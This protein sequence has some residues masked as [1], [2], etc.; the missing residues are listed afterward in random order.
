M[1]DSPDDVAALLA[2]ILALTNLH[3]LV[4]HRS[5]AALRGD[6]MRSAAHLDRHHVCCW[7]ALCVCLGVCVCVLIW[8]TVAISQPEPARACRYSVANTASELVDAATKAKLLK[9]GERVP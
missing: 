9:V 8:R 2:K 3:R 5:L 1:R 6:A 4:S 7:S